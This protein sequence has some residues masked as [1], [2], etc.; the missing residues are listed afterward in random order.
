VLVVA[1]MALFGVFLAQRAIVCSHGREPVEKIG[2]II[3]EPPQGAAERLPEKAARRRGRE[4]MSHTNPKPY[5]VLAPLP[6]FLACPRE[7]VPV[8][9]AS[10]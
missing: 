2:P 9:F 7:G 10:A 1:E 3:P 8:Y 5:F 4:E 6:S